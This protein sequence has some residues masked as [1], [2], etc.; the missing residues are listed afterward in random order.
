VKEVPDV[1]AIA[2]FV[3]QKQ[4]ASILRR[5][6]SEGG[7]DHRRAKERQNQSEQLLEQSD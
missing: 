4:S 1:K 6:A 5:R 3:Q 2:V 7:T